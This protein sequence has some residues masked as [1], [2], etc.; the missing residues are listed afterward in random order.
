MNRDRKGFELRT[1]LAVEERERFG[2][3]AGALAGV[4]REFDS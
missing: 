2:D 4:K 3:E 1:D